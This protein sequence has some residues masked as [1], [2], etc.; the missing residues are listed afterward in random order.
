M[1][2]NGNIRNIFDWLNQIY[3]QKSSVNSF[4][5]GDWD[6]WNSYLIH[7]WVSQ[8]PSYID[9]VNYVQKMNPQGKKEIYSVYRELIPRKKQWNKYI[10]NENKKN[11]Q[12]LS[13]YLIKYYQ[14]SVKETY[15][16]ID[17]LGKDGVRSILTDMGLE[18]KEITKLFKKAKL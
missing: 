14:C 16:Y 5:E 15:N 6:K 2:I 4:T 11:Y 12:D 18:K 1:G 10:K 13:E 7:R 17:I 9:I 3:V 8:N